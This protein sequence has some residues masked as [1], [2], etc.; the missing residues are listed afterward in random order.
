[1]RYLEIASTSTE[2]GRPRILTLLAA[3]SRNLRQIVLEEFDA[4]CINHVL[5]EV[6]IY[7]Y[8]SKDRPGIKARMSCDLDP[9]PIELLVVA[10]PPAFGKALRVPRQQTLEGGMAFAKDPFLQQI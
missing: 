5:W 9:V 2:R 3:R 6:I 10:L 8:Y 4:G 7:I 1:M